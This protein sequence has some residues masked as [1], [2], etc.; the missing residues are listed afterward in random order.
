LWRLATHAGVG[1]ALPICHRLERQVKTAIAFTIA[2]LIGAG[3]RW[4]E[5]PVPS[6][7]KLIGALLVLT[8]SVGYL[9]TDRLMARSQ[10]ATHRHSSA[11]PDMQR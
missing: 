8:M 10:S 11:R 2:L 3:C 5:I 7:P 1:I 4:F 6:P 9:A